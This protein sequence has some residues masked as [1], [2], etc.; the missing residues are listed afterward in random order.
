MKFNPGDV[1]TADFPGVT[2]VKR[3]PVGV[4]MK[5]MLDCLEVRDSPCEVPRPFP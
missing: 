5:I 4:P 3:R 2:G 1:V